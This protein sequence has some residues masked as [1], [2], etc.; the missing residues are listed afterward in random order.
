MSVHI[1][2]TPVKGKP[3]HYKVDVRI[4]EGT[5][6]P[7]FTPEIKLRDEHLTSKERIE[8]KRR[9]YREVTP[10]LFFDIFTSFF[11]FFG[12][13]TYD[14]KQ[15]KTRAEKLENALRDEG[16]ATARVKVKVNP[17]ERYAGAIKPVI[18]VRQG[19]KLHV[20]FIGNPAL[21]S[22]ELKTELTFKKSGVIDELELELELELQSC[23]ELGTIALRAL[24]VGQ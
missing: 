23:F 21:K 15:I 24:Q 5:Q 1:V 14:H 18:D 9:I 12:I 22:Q 13:G 4:S 11:K 17:K 3:K 6:P 8:L 20:Q 19:P 7:L 10:D 16:W 2:R